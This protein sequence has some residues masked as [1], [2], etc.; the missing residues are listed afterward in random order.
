VKEETHL[1][2]TSPQNLTEPLFLLANGFLNVLSSQIYL[3]NGGRNLLLE[4][5]Y[6]PIYAMPGNQW[7]ILLPNPEWGL[8]LTPLNILLVTYVY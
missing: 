5:V 7:G 1:P 3:I 6:R 8:V 4:G 2:D